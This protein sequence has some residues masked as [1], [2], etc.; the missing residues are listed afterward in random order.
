MILFLLLL[1]IFG[2]QEGIYFKIQTSYIPVVTFCLCFHTGQRLKF[3]TQV[4]GP[5]GQ[6]DVIEHRFL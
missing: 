1:I 6:K 4:K 3:Y 5:T 2:S